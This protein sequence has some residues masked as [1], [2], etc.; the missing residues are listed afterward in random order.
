LT[1]RI[2]KC[3]VLFM[4]NLYAMGLTVIV[5]SW[6]LQYLSITPKKQDFN[7]LFLMFY[8][9]GTAVLAWISYISGSPLTALL[10]LGAFILPIAILLKI[11][12]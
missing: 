8:A 9:I 6:L 1:E 12:K 10:N 2:D 11:K 3:Y 4:E 5:I 7:P